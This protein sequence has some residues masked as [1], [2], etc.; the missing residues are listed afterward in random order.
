[1]GTARN[2]HAW[3]SITPE[4]ERELPAAIA[5]LRAGG[6]PNDSAIELERRRAEHLITRA[7]RRAWL[8]YLADAAALARAADGEG[9]V[10]EARALVLDVVDNHDKLRLGLPGGHA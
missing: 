9:E 7:S 3:L 5:T 4:P 1:M 10:A 8:A 2:R 6:V